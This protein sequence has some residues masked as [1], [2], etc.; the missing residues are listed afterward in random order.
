M[1]MLMVVLVISSDSS[2]DSVGGI[3]LVNTGV[4]ISILTDLELAPLM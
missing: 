4:V 2:S 3:T 1:M